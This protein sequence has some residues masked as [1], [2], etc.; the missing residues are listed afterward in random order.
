MLRIG[1]VQLQGNVLLAPIAGHCDLPFRLTARSF[2]GL[3]IAYT[4]L[5]C[6]HGILRQNEQTLWLASSSPEDHPLGMQLYGVDP[7]LMAAAALWA[8]EQGATLIDIN[9]GCP[10]DKVTKTFAGSKM[11]CTPDATVAVAARLVKTVKV[12]VTAKMR[13]GYCHG[14]LVAPLL[15]RKLAD[16]GVAAITVHGRTAE[17]RFKGVVDRSGI[18]AVVRELACHPSVPVIGNGDIRTP[19]DAVSMM[20][21]TGCAGVMIARAAL[22]APWIFRD[23]QALISTGSLPPETTLRQR[24]AAIL[25]HIAQVRALRTDRHALQVARQKIG[26]YSKFLGPC[27]PLR[28]AIIAMKRLEDVEPAFLRFLEEAGPQADQTPITWHDRVREYELSGHANPSLEL[29]AEA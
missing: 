13:L 17:Q 9:M 16:V 21:Q 23:T 27:K 2:G 28:M 12:P 10:V 24:V 20:E 14:E 1:N 25:F 7:D 5:L 4:D 26:G 19:F 3:A 18:A 6:P 29:S 11:L 15:A 8:Q 22:A